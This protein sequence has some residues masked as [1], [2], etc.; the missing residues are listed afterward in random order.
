MN[1]W[2]ITSSEEALGPYE[3]YED[4][5]L[6]ATINFGMTGWTITKT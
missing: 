2:V 6:A 4:A 5:Y 3:S 1:Y